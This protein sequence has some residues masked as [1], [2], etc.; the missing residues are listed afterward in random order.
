MRRRRH[1]VNDKIVVNVVDARVNRVHVVVVEKIV[2]RVHVVVVSSSRVVVV[3]LR[4]VLC[5]LQTM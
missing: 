4:V 2:V 5:I 3:T 1:V